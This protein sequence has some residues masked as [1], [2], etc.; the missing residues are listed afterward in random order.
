MLWKRRLLR[1]IRRF[2]KGNYS[3]TRSRFYSWIYYLK[4]E[5]FVASV[6]CTW[7]QIAFKW[8]MNYW[9]QLSTQWDGKYFNG[10]NFYLEHRTFFKFTKTEAAE[11]SYELAC[12]F[13]APS[14]SKN[15]DWN[16]QQLMDSDILANRNS[17]NHPYC[18]L[19]NQKE[20]QIMAF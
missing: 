12:T 16:Q 7:Y 4:S 5:S 20:I 11:I 3:Q 19:S 13:T 10:S 14:A 8:S 6:T 1:I 9:L 17:A 2:L 18:F 15:V